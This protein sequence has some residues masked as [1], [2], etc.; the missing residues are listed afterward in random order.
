MHLQLWV[1]V[2]TL[3]S[4]LLPESNQILLE[5]GW[6]DVCVGKLPRCSL[7][8][9]PVNVLYKSILSIKKETKSNYQPIK[10]A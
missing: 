4:N 10:C 1:E 5:K 2:S 3:V 9:M 7:D 8:T 6:F